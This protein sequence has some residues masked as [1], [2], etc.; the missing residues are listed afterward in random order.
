MPDP[1]RLLCPSRSVILSVP[2][3]RFVRKQGAANFSTRE[4]KVS[5]PCRKRKALK[6]KIAAPA[7][8]SRMAL[9]YMDEVPASSS[10]MLGA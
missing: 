4:E 9:I 10:L 3:K 1:S 7:S 6:G 5:V 8:R 2:L